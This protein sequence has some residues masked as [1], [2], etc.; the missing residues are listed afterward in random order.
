MYQSAKELA[1]KAK[2]RVSGLAVGTVATGM[3]LVNQAQAALPAEASAAFTSLSGNVPDISAA[4]WPILA[5]VTGG[6][7][8]MKLF[9]R[10][11]SK[12]V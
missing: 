4:V 9:K 8:L 3:L 1:F 2:N 5:A 11:T 10:G 7:A 6:F 12:A